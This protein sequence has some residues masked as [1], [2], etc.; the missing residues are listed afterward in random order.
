MASP[1]EK[2]DTHWVPPLGCH[3]AEIGDLLEAFG[4]APKYY[5]KQG[6]SVYRHKNI[7][8]QPEWTPFTFRHANPNIGEQWHRDILNYLERMGKKYGLLP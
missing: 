7:K 4:Y 1:R 6:V 5:D 2:L 8:H 3:I